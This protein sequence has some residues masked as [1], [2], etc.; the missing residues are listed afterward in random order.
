MYNF[1]FSSK[2]IPPSREYPQGRFTNYTVRA[3]D[4]WVSDNALG[5]LALRMQ[6]ER[7]KTLFNLNVNEYGDSGHIKTR[8]YKSKDCQDAFT[9]YM[10]WINFPRCNPESGQTLPTCRSA[11]ENF[12]IT[13]GYE[14]KLWRCGKTKYFNGYFPESQK[15]STSLNSS[16]TYYREYFPGQPFRKNKKVKKTGDEEPICT[17]AIRGSGG[18][19]TL[20]GTMKIIFMIIVLLLS[21]LFF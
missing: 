10:C 11:C 2:A 9:N 4:Q 20:T 7:N 19:N 1:L 18:K 16:Y 5:Q 12:F 8:F 14:S 21:I 6:L 17:P 15:T 3:K 13:C